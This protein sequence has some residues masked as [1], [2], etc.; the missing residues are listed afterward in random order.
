MLFKKHNSTYYGN[1][2]ILEKHMDV[3]LEEI[4]KYIKPL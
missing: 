1:Q 2:D 3:P 4:P